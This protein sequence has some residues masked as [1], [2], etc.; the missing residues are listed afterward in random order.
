MTEQI[1]YRDYEIYFDP[2]PIPT[3]QWDWHFM[4]VAFDGDED[5]RYGHCA[6]EQACRDE[7]DERYLEEAA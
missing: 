1:I 3:R 5:P 6:S 2:P 7:I 4:H